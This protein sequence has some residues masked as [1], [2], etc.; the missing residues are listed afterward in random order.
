MRFTFSDANN[1]KIEEGEEEAVS[2]QNNISNK[3]DP[4]NKAKEFFNSLEKKVD[5]LETE[6]G[7]MEFYRSVFIV[8]EK[9]LIKEVSGLKLWT[10]PSVST[11]MKELFFNK[12]YFFAPS[13]VET[14]EDLMTTFNEGSRKAMGRIL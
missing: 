8:I 3:Q 10:K 6:K 1:V 13:Q 9:T 12:E 5:K 11:F 14:L 4:T 2:L 7:M